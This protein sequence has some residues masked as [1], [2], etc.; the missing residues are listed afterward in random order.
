MASNRLAPS[1]RANQDRSQ[2]GGQEVAKT[3]NIA[4]LDKSQMA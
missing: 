4:A 2:G 3:G 1:H